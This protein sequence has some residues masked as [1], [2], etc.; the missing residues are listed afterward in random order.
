[1][2]TTSN[3]QSVGRGYAS[4]FVA[5]VQSADRTLIGV[6]LGLLCIERDVP[7]LWVAEQ[8]GVSR[9]TVYRWFLGAPPQGERLVQ[10][11]KLLARLRS[12]AS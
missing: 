5:R 12:T 8:T 10:V 1:M 3:T 11:E 4:G 6:Q 9:Q 2:M 7:V